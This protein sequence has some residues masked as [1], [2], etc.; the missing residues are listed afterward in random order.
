MQR[1]ALGSLDS[2]HD[3]LAT[4]L[5]AR[6]ARACVCSVAGHGFRHAD[7]VLADLTV[8]CEYAQVRPA[9][10]RQGAHVERYQPDLALSMQRL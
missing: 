5:D 10:G 7:R 2:A 3:S 4:T 8:E 6:T 9:L 1:I